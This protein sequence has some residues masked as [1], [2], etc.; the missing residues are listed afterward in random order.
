MKYHRMK[1]SKLLSELDSEEI[2]GCGS[3]WQ[4]SMVRLMGDNYI[5]RRRQLH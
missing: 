2:A 5:D 3:G 1:F 4:N